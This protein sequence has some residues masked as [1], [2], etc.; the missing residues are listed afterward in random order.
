MNAKEI[1]AAADLT[2]F[3][4]PNPE[5]EIDGAYACDLLSQVLSHAKAGCAW[6]TIM[7]NINVI[8]VALSANIGMTILCEG[9]LPDEKMTEAA[10]SNGINL[11][12]TRLST[13]ELCIKLSELI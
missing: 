2:I 3:S 1:A 12:G 13:Y 4:M 6:A 5:R 11:F 9:C 8:A 10:K 7:T